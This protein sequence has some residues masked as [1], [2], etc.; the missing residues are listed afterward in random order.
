MKP[1]PASLILAAAAVSAM[2]LCALAQPSG[3]RSATGFSSV[4][5]YPA[6]HEQ[7]V[8]ERLSGAEAQPLAGGL[9]L[10]KQLRLETFAEDGKPETIVT[11]PE[12]TYDSPNGVAYSAGPLRVDSADGNFQLEGEGFLWHQTNSCLNISNSVRA[13]IHGM[14]VLPEAATAAGKNKSQ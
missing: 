14:P 4:D 2:A 6:P 13:V 7:Q 1:I 5:Y 12:C 10:I 9:L 3:G 8:K 11:A